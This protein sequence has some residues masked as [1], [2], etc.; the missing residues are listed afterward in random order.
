MGGRV[1]FYNTLIWGS[2]ANVLITDDVGIEV[3][4][5]NCDV[6]YIAQ[7]FITN[8]L[9]KDFI[10]VI[11]TDPFFIDPSDLTGSDP[12]GLLADWNISQ[13]SSCINSGTEGIPGISLPGSDLNGMPR[14]TPPIIIAHIASGA[15]SSK[16]KKDFMPTRSIK[17]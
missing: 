15:L 10:N 11:D 14:I 1:S 8:G 16:V 3:N 5:Y 12:D 2:P 4:F 7:S 17:L 9:V 6:E 13:F